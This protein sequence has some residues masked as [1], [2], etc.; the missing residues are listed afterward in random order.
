MN[1]KQAYI[2]ALREQKSK[3]ILDS[4]Q[5]PNRYMTR[6]QVLLHYVVLRQRGFI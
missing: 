2:K 5:N 4:A 3:W 1:K 6:T